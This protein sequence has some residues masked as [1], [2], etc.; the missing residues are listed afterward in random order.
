[1]SPPPRPQRRLR[2][3]RPT[4]RRA[5]TPMPSAQASR[6]WPA[7]ASR[8]T[9]SWCGRRAATVPASTASTSCSAAASRSSPRVARS[10]CATSPGAPSSPRP[11]PELSTS[12]TAMTAHSCSAAASCACTPRTGA[13][14]T[15][16]RPRT[17]SSRGATR[18]PLRPTRRCRP[19]S[20]A[21]SRLPGC[22]PTQTFG[23]GSTTFT[24][25]RRSSRP[26]GQCSP[27]RGVSQSS[28]GPDPSSYRLEW[29]QDSIG[30]EKGSTR[31]R[32]TCAFLPDGDGALRR[33][34]RY[35]RRAQPPP[36][37]EMVRACVSRS[38]SA[39]NR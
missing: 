25:S 5:T 31:R 13:P 6:G 20:P 15:C 27:R 14:S 38:R 1:M 22:A 23:T 9:A 36:R 33:R 18:S 24:G 37:S 29:R 30:G 8:A 28:I 7:S 11:S 19:P 26:T 4:R 21:R 2:R 39:L 10:G 12:Q 32:F 3:R 17:R 34:H 16:T 35:T